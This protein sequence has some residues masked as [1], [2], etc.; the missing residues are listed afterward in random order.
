V[1]LEPERPVIILPASLGSATAKVSL[2]DPEGECLAAELDERTS[3][4]LWLSY[5]VPSCCSTPL[6]LVMNR[7]KR[8]ENI[9]RLMLPMLQPGFIT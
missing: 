5:V 8:N 9:Y 3:I 7:T 4:G 6:L 2:A 1:E